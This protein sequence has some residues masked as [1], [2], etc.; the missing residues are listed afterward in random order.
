MSYRELFVTQG[1]GLCVDESFVVR[2]KFELVFELR[3]SNQSGLLLHVG[4]LDHHLTVFMRKGEVS[5][6]FY[7]I[8]RCGHNSPYVIPANV[9]ALHHFVPVFSFFVKNSLAIEE[10]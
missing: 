3:P 8:L 1:F 5:S 4:N 6:V 10:F 9:R 7:F 2:Q